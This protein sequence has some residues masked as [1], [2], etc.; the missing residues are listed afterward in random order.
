MDKRRVGVRAIIWHDSKLLAVRH[1]SEKTGGAK[2]FWAIPG[3]GLDPGESLEDCLRREVYEELGVEAVPGRLLFTQQF[4]STREDYNEE[5]EFFF[6]IEN[7][8]DFINIDYSGTSHGLEELVACEFI[9]PKAEYILPKFIS[10]VDIGSYADQSQPVLMA[11][12][13][14]VK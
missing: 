5:L 1:R 13:L 3:G 7:H 8:Q 14:D 12:L 11:N 9:D 10:Q 2:D 6:L 4:V